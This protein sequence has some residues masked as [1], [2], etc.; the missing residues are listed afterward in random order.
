MVLEWETALL[1]LGKRGTNF[2]YKNYKLKDGR[3][4]HFHDRDEGWDYTVY[5]AEG[6]ELDG[7]IYES[8]LEEE[9]TE[10]QVLELLAEFAEIPEL[11]DKTQLTEIEEI[12]ETYLDK[13][14]D[15]SNQ[16]EI[17]LEDN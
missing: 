6:K 4:F 5:D 7:G 2:M 9:L 11:L 16:D 14:Q 15:S 8:D 17:E 3:Q 12:V 13:A 1:F 10:D